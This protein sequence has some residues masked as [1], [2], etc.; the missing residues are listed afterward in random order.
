MASDVLPAGTTSKPSE[1]PEAEQGTI[2]NNVL[3]V[4]EAAAISLFSFAPAV[5]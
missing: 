5:V 3:P 2:L 4:G 1:Y